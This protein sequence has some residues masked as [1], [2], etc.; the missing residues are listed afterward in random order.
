MRSLFDEN[1]VCQVAFLEAQERSLYNP[2]GGGAPQAANSAQW[3]ELENSAFSSQLGIRRL[4]E[5]RSDIGRSTGR[6]SLS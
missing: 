5:A 2:W 3:E 1:H 6:V 4:L